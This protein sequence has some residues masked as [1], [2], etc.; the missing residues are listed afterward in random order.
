MELFQTMHTQSTKW[1]NALLL[2]GGILAAPMLPAKVWILEFVAA[3][4]GSVVDEDGDDEDWIEI[5]NDSNATVDLSGW[6]LSDDA[7]DLQKWIFPP[8]TSLAAKKFLTVFASGKN[9]RVVGD[10]FHTNFK[11]SSRGEYLG[12][13]KADGSTVEHEFAPTYPAQVEGASYGVGQGSGAS[14]MIETGASG[15]AAVP[16]DQADFNANY[17]NWNDAPGSTFTGSTWRAVTTGVGFDNGA[18]YDGWLSESGDFIN[19]MFGGN[20]SVFIR[21]PFDLADSNAVNGMTLRMRYDDGFIAYING[22][23]V[24]ADREDATPNWNSLA[25]ASRSDGLN[26]E[27]EVFAINLENVELVTGT[28]VLA[29]HGMNRSLGNSD[30]LILPELDVAITGGVTDTPGY[31]SEPSF[32][33]ANEGIADEVAPVIKNVTDTPDRPVGGGGSAPLLITAEVSDGTGS[34]D[35]VRLYSRIMFGSENM[36]L[37][38]DGGT[39]GDETAGDGIYSALLATTSLDDGEM[40][41]WRVEAEDDDNAVGLSP[42]YPDPLDSDRYYGTVA[43]N[44]DH[45][46]S[47]LPIIETFVQNQAAV[48]TVSGTRTS[49]YYLGQFYDNIQMDRHG[50]STGGFPK[51]SYDVDF[52]KGNRFEWREGERRVKDINLLTNWADKSKVRNTLTYEYLNRTG[53]KGHYAFTVRMDRNGEFFSTTDMVEDG[54]DRYLDRV[55]LDEE[56]TLYKMYD[57]LASTNGGSKKTPKDGDKS[58]LQALITALASSSVANKRR[59]AYDNIDVAATINQLAAYATAGITDSGH[60]NYYMYRD[61][62]GTGEWRPL[63]WDVDLSFGRKWTGTLK[64]FDDNMVTNFEIPETINPLWALMQTTP[65]FR[66]MMVRRIDTLR[67]DLFL[68]GAN[69]AANGDWIKD[70]IIAIRNQIGTD[71]DR[72]Y[73]KWG[74]WGNNFNMLQGSDR[75]IDTFLPARRSFIFNTGFEVNNAQIASTE[76]TTPSVDIE[77][78]DFLPLS[79][80]QDEEYIVLK[81]REGSADIDLSGWTL[82]GGVDYTFPE[83]TVILAGAGTSASGYQ[84]LLHVARDS[85]SFRARTTGPKGGEFRYVQGGYQGQLSARGESIELRNDSGVLIDSFTYTGTPTVNQ[86]ALRVTEVNYHPADPTAAESAALPG[87]VDSDFEFLELKNISGASIDLGNSSFTEG[88]EYT[89]DAPLTLAAGGRIILAKNPAAF[90][91]RYPAVSSPV[92]GPFIGQLDNDGETLR[93]VD[94]VGENILVFT[95][96]DRWYPPSDGGGLSLVIRDDATAY[97]ELSDPAM[98]AASELAGGSPGIGDTSWQV[99]FNAW[100]EGFFPSAEWLTDGAFDADPDGDGRKNWEEYAY[101]T[102]PLV[103]DAAQVSGTEV[104]VEGVDYLAIEV[105]RVSNGADLVWSLQKSATLASWPLEPSVLVTNT[106]NGDGSETAVIRESSILGTDERKFIRLHLELLTE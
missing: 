53:A 104:E 71:A 57:R 85:A 40:I 34:V 13:M 87:V 56:G 25:S 103:A 81:N 100:Q 36:I 80:N 66:E 42:P 62:H 86:L 9:R 76:P 52:N 11:L 28:N 58:D 22:V 21:L 43:F 29:I 95:Y 84:G 98:W 90:A 106:S 64:Y 14:T 97:N 55:G 45:N 35:E 19:E 47:Q 102:N 24:A 77:S 96:N 6:S 101:A 83:G 32:G 88:V 68:S 63:P 72:D 49:L 73:A 99:H 33:S 51:K 78:V 39:A 69:A 82:S 41:R 12:L 48:D 75:I 27:W 10:E 7:A 65:E 16:V 4:D 3:N 74:S 17:L 67:D 23:Q 89:F 8:G 26:S 38:N 94:G 60:K 2:A 1:W 20:T 79:G 46:S 31:F 91:I 18:G 92:A 50:Q 37:M 93:L 54:D 105:R 15:Q 70:S 59:Y 61:T 5:Y 30:M 44:P